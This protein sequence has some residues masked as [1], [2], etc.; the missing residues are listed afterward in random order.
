MVLYFSVLLICDFKE[1]QQTSW[2]FDKPTE[3]NNYK[4][5]MYYDHMASN[6]DSDVSTLEIL[7]NTELSDQA[8][9][10]LKLFT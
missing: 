5:W 3:F 4:H 8:K 1:W 6:S 9:I 7:S 2:C 10:H